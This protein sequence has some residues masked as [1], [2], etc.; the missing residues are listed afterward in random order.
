MKIILIILVFIFCSELC[1][2]GGKGNVGVL[3]G[4]EAV[5][6][7]FASAEI[8][9]FN[10]STFYFGPN[11]GL[12]FPS[13]VPGGHLGVHVGYDLGQFFIEAS[14]S[15]FYMLA[16]HAENSRAGYGYYTFNPKIGIRIISI[17]RINFHIKAGPG[18]FISKNPL[19]FNGFFLEIYRKPIN[20]ELGLT[21]DLR[22]VK[23]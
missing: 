14:I 22:S 12:F 19:N 7:F 23:L 17:E 5:Y 18:F 13:I 8:Y 21:I 9:P 15:G 11:I 10:D 4:P 3:Y 2:S 6:G 1:F 16:A 20:I